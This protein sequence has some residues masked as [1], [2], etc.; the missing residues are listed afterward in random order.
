MKVMSKDNV[1][2]EI[3]LHDCVFSPDTSCDL[4]SSDRVWFRKISGKWQISHFLS[5]VSATKWINNTNSSVI[6]SYQ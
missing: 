2:F 5:L 1:E 4:R 6:R 3:R